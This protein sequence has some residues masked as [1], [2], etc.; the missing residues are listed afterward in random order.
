MRKRLIRRKHAFTNNELHTIIER[1]T[2]HLQT[3]IIKT[4]QNGA[5][6][7]NTIYERLMDEK[8]NTIFT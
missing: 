2:K 7:L 1:E 8:G 5:L 6:G 4:K 3:A